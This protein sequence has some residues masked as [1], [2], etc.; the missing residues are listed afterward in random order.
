MLKQ[1]LKEFTKDERR[2]FVDCFQEGAARRRARSMIW[3][4][5]LLLVAVILTA[6]SGF[7]VTML[8]ILATLVLM[9]AAI[10]KSS[11]QRKMLHYESLVRKLTHRVEHLE[12]VPLTPSEAD[13]ARVLRSTSVRRPTPS[14]SQPSSTPIRE[15]VQ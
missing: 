5:G 4:T 11:Y 6:T 15:G 2:V 8:A 3:S 9:V 7:G 13:P 14:A 1:D 12:G 10:E